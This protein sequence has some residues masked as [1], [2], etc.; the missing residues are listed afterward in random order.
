[1]NI[2]QLYEA[3]TTA[4]SDETGASDSLLHVHAGMAVLILARIATGRSLATPVPLLVVLAAA[5]LNEVFDRIN[6][7]QWRWQD[8]SLDMLNTLFWPFVLMTGLRVRRSLEAR[9]PRSRRA[10]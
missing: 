6:H 1:M 4:L 9:R 5:Q 7:G 3:L 2:A 8:T 10:D